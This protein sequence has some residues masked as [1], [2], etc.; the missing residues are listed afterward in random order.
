MLH[1]YLLYS[2]FLI[3]IIIYYIGGFFDSGL[4][5]H[6]GYYGWYGYSNG[7]N[8]FVIMHTSKS[9]TYSFSEEARSETIAE[10][11]LS[12]HLVLGLNSNSIPCYFK[13]QICN[14]KSSNHI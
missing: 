6:Y 11:Q 4:N 3:I 12:E 7:D 9:S 8:A 10:S 2:L 5:M 1:W 13:R 14:S